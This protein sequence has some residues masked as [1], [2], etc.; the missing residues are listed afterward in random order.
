MTVRQPPGKKGPASKSKPCPPG[1]KKSDGTKP[2]VTKPK[3]K[4]P[5]VKPETK[6]KIGKEGKRRPRP[7]GWGE[8][9]KPEAPK[10]TKPKA[11]PKP[12]G[13][14]KPPNKRTGEDYRDWAD[15]RERLK[16]DKNRKE[17]YGKPMP[18]KI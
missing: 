12:E 13:P 17:R 18:Y 3:D 8:G 11:R 4:K 5:K 16:K 7:P 6:E 14:K 10:K 1:S 2:H 15:L 9:S